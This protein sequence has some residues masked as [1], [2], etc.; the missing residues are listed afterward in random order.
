[1]NITPFDPFRSVFP[2]RNK[3]LADWLLSDSGT[4]LSPTEPA[5]NPAVDIKEDDTRFVVTADIPGVNPKDIE[6]TMDHGV[7]T[8]KGER[9]SEKSEE[10]ESYRRVERSYGSFVR[11]FAFPESVDVESISAKGKDGVLEIVIPKKPNSVPK[12]ISVA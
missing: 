4:N 1:M 3:S 2:S 12:K 6:V 11:R 9:S 8:V 7:L 5:W 10:K